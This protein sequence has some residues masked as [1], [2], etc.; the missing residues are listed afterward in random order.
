M[1]ALIQ[2]VDSISD[3]PT[4]RLDVN[5]GISWFCQLFNAPPP[6]LRRSESENSMRD[7]GVVGSSSYSNRTLEI[8]LTLVEEA[9]EDWAAQ[10]MQ[11]L[12]RELDRP[13]NFIRYWPEWLDKPV[14]FRTF[15]SD[16]SELEELWTTPIARNITLEVLAE[17]FALGLRET[18]GPY[19]VNNDPAAGSNPCYV[20]ISGVIGDVAVSPVLLIDPSSPMTT[21]WIATGANRY[22]SQLESATPLQA[23]TTNPGGGPDAV[24]SGTGTNNYLRT[25]FATTASLVG[26]V[27]SNITVEQGTYRLLVAL[28]RSDNTSVMTVK[29][30]VSTDEATIVTTLPL[31]TSRILVDLG[32]LTTRHTAL[33]TSGYAAASNG[34]TV[35]EQVTIWAGRTSGSGTLDFDYFALIPANEASLIARA[36][37]IVQGVVLDGVRDAATSWLS[38]DPLAG[39]A[40]ADTRAVGMAGSIPTL[41]PNVTTRLHLLQA[42]AVGAHSKSV[43]TAVTVGYWPRYLYVRPASS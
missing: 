43:N 21:C 13:Q 19:A 10:E 32:V 29:G 15:R 42:A 4:V 16:A 9:D 25:T 17:P 31:T 36:A 30:S 6:R 11:K 39:T 27:S 22:V 35:G 18:L 33:G 8:D 26:R 24:M 3:A 23:D 40:T 7:G 34:T 37:S 20:D 5:D 2:F 28:R 14:F 1:A 12:W 38:G 41:L